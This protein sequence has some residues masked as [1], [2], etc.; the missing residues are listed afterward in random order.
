MPYIYSFQDAQQDA[1][2]LGNKGANLVTMTMLGLPVP[3]GFIVSIDAYNEYKKTG[4]IPEIEISLAIANLEQQVN[5]GLGKDL[6]LSVRSSAPISMP[7][8]MDTVLNL[9]NINE[10]T[11]AIKKVFSS[12]SGPRALEYQRLNRISSDL[13]TSAIVQVMVYGNK[14]VN[15]GT[16][17]IF[18]RDP[19]TGRKGLFGEY[20]SQAQGE[21]LVSGARTPSPISE[22]QSQMPN[23]YTELQQIASLLEKYYRDVQDIEFTIESKKLY[24]LQTRSA[25]R[26]GQAAVKIV[27]DMVHEGLINT[28]EAIKRLRVEDLQA[29]LHKH[30]KS[31]ELFQPLAAG[32]PAA[33]GVACGQVVFDPVETMMLAKKG[34][35]VILV[36]PDTSPDDIQG[37][38]AADGILTSKGGLTS[39]A[40]IITRAMGKPCVCGAEEIDID[41]ELEL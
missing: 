6:E 27:V 19:S 31:P 30:I 26:S 11:E 36:R 12:R 14:D 16:G 24:I 32:L 25:K 15:S 20:L 5:R 35:P 10:V 21:D 22:L 39:H 17:V 38:A 2:I 4:N 28:E 37:I 18:T 9:K 33:P 3:P 13:G 41:L 23:V 1:D 29:L 40:A 7:G 8:M 34:I